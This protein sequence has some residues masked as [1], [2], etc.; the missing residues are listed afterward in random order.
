MIPVPA[1]P[2]QH[3]QDVPVDRLDGAEGDL[4][5]AVVQDP[6][7]MARQQPAEL[8]EGR[9]PAQGAQLGGQEA[10]GPAFVGVGPQSG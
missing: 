8:R 10:P 9:R 6:V 1:P 4:L 7:E 2:A 3:G 5:V